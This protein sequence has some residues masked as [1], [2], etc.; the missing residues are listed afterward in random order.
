MSSRG[1]HEPNLTVKSQSLHTHSLKPRDR[2]AGQNNPVQA[3]QVKTSTRVNLLCMIRRGF[4]MRSADDYGSWTSVYEAIETV[5][6]SFFR[7]TTNF[8]SCFAVLLLNS[9]SLL[10]LSKRR[11]RNFTNTS[12]EPMRPVHWARSSRVYFSPVQASVP[13]GARDIRWSAAYPV[14]WLA[15]VR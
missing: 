14:S 7:L 2:A 3:C 10:E 4:N 5:V 11:W 15:K 1:W 8:Y 9:S 13:S 6:L 12:F